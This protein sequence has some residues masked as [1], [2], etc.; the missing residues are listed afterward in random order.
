MRFLG[1]DLTVLGGQTVRPGVILVNSPDS[2]KKGCFLVSL[3]G[4]QRSLDFG[5]HRVLNEG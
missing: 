1:P 3:F 2:R 5:A 4:D